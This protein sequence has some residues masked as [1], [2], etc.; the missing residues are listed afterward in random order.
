[1]PVVNLALMADDSEQVIFVQCIRARIAA[2]QQISHA[3][4]EFV[5]RNVGLRERIRR[6]GFHFALCFPATAHDE[7]RVGRHIDRGGEPH[8]RV[9]LLRGRLIG[10]SVL[11]SLT[12]RSASQLRPDI[13]CSVPT[14][15]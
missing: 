3:H 11:E 7:G 15:N 8:P 9:D 13:C 14:L 5:I 2:V 6:G 1:M 10:R 4:T 12:G